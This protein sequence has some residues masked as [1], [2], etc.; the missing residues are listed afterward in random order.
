MAQR[1]TLT[2]K[3]RS[4]E[5]N[6]KALRRHKTIPA[7]LYGHGLESQRLQVDDK[8]LVRVFAS[9][10]HTSLV[11]MT[12][13]G[14]KEEMHPVI[15][16]SIERHP[17]SD[18][19]EHVDF[20]K[21]RLDE[22]ITVNVPLR[23]EGTSAAVKDRGGVLVRTIDALEIQALPTDMPHDIEVDISTLTDFEKVIHVRDLRI[24]SGIEILNQEEDDVVALVQPP[25][26]EEELEAL[27][28]E[29]TE[30]VESVEGV[31]DKQEEDAEEADGEPADQQP[32]QSDA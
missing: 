29:A 12:I 2:V 31:E 15:I 8:S 22:K 11:S 13:A 7:V 10:G 4:R 32:G 21:V 5:E 20:F 9:A 28:E 3:P 1:I 24:P 26:S 23:F 19:I 16:R 25:R 18:A 14:E 17:L 6:V 27:K 30:D